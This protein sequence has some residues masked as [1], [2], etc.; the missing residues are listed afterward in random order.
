M[1]LIIVLD[2]TTQTQIVRLL[3]RLIAFSQLGINT[4]AKRNYRCICYLKK[5]NS[6][7]LDVENVT[8]ILNHN[9]PSD[10]CAQHPFNYNVFLSLDFSCFAIGNPVKLLLQISCGIIT[11]RTLDKLSHLHELACSWK[12]S[13]IIFQYYICFETFF[14]GIDLSDTVC[15]RCKYH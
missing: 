7:A 1:C 3:N 11:Q 15:A 9:I 6:A 5:W 12:V 14:S 8:L 4:G 10:A 2:T 13:T